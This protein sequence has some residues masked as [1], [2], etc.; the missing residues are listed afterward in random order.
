ML[1]K[2]TSPL[3]F[4]TTFHSVGSS[5]QLPDRDGVRLLR[6]AWPTIATSSPLIELPEFA[7]EHALA[8]DLLPTVPMCCSGA[9]ALAQSPLLGRD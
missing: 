7:L 6:S 5:A 3:A 9:R 8:A 4:T 2:N 1:H